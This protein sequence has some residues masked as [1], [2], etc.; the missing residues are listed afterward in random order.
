MSLTV[1]KTY[2]QP[3]LGRN[4]E[5]GIFSVSSVL[6]LGI[7]MAVRGCSCAIQNCIIDYYNPAGLV[8][9]GLIGYENKTPGFQ[10]CTCAGSQTHL[11]YISTLTTGSKDTIMIITAMWLLLKSHSFLF[12]EQCSCLHYRPQLPESLC[13]HTSGSRASTHPHNLVPHNLV[14]P[15][16]THS[17]MVCLYV[18][19]LSQYYC[20]PILRSSLAD[21]TL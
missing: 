17:T 14:P 20:G 21:T 6:C 8:T 11:C 1:G 3:L 12:Q 13:H 9:V 2:N 10:C 5:M 15:Q 4:W 16:H 18:L 19:I 7:C